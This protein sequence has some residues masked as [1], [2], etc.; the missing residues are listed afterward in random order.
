MCG[1]FTLRLTPTE[2]AQFFRLVSEP[3]IAPR[4]NIA[5]TQAVAVVRQEGNARELVLMRWGLIPAWAKDGKSGAS[6]INA[7]AETV[8]EKPSFR[9]AFQK[10]RC[11]IPADGFF[12]WRKAGNKTKQPFFI[13]LRNDQP[14]AFA[15]LWERWK[16]PNG[17]P[18]E[19]CTLI[20]TTP[21]KR[22]AEIHDRMPV[23]LPNT[24]WD[25]WLDS[26]IQNGASVQSLLV[27]YP[28]SEMRTYR[29]STLV[30]S[31]RN[32]VP[33]CLQPVPNDKLFD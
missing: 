26:K 18:I 23:I 32:D 22:L 12:E 29:V 33:A 30:N 2:L 13:G 20:T 10:R 3:A 21:N 4:Y 25:V 14:F 15:G 7:R 27:P 5:P 16:S 31:P 24:V 11:L 6:L 1:R 17:T 19:S 9:S 28:A 8:A